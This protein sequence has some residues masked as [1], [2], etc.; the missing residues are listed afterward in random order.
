LQKLQLRKTRLR[1]GI[2]LLGRQATN[3]APNRSKE[4]ESFDGLRTS[5]VGRLK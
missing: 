2:H 1:S 5:Q 3:L 4:S